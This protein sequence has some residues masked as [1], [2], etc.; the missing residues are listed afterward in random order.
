MSGRQID[1]DALNQF[2]KSTRYQ[3]AKKPEKQKAVG[4]PATFNPQAVPEALLKKHEEDKKLKRRADDARS[5]RRRNYR[6]D[7][8]GFA[9]WE[10]FALSEANRGEQKI[11]EHGLLDTDYS[12]VVE[13]CGLTQLPYKTKRECQWLFLSIIDRAWKNM[14]KDWMPDPFRPMP[15]NW[16][17]DAAE[18]WDWVEGEE[19]PKNLH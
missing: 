11:D 19:S 8:P 3:K 13:Q 7:Y 17:H 15:E 4:D 9:K 10:K 18:F 14:P 16:K 5:A 12:D 2:A 6:Q 1:W